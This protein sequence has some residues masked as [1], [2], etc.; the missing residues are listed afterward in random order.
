VTRTFI[1]H[2]VEM[3]VVMFVGMA[4][5]WMPAKPILSALG[6]SSADLHDAPA[7]YLLAMA[8]SMSVPMV[9]WMRYRGHGWQ[10]SLEMAASMY[11]PTLLATVLLAIGLVTDLGSLM[12]IQHNVML[13]A[14]LVAMLLR[15]EEYSRPHA[16]HKAQLEVAS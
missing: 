10:P 12:L 8:T 3:V 13:P 9:A 14:M 4:I 1:R 2:Y 7:A 11:L 6:T 16:A 5:V 15:R